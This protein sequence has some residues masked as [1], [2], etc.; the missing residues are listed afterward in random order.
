MKINK[1]GFKRSLSKFMRNYKIRTR[2]L[3]V[4]IVF[5][6]VPTILVFSIAKYCATEISWTQ[7]KSHVVSGQESIEKNIELLNNQIDIFSLRMI[8]DGDLY[9]S[10][11]NT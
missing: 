1:Y 10:L 3:C 2:I 4:L 9:Y 5:T 7:L 8:M 11:R 6:L